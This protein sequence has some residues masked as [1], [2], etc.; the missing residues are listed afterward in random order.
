METPVCVLGQS[1]SSKQARWLFNFDLRIPDS[2]FV[3]I[4]LAIRAVCERKFAR[5]AFAKKEARD[6][7]RV[8]GLGQR[9]TREFQTRGCRHFPDVAANGLPA[10]HPLALKRRL[11]SRAAHLPGHET[12]LKF[13]GVS[14]LDQ[15]THGVT[16]R[17]S[18]STPASPWRLATVE[19]SDWPR[20]FR[21]RRC[22]ISAAAVLA[23]G[24]SDLFTTTMSA[25]SSIAIFCNCNR[26]P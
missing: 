24:K 19:T 11:G 17:K 4:H 5:Q 7:T 10:L 16:S 26:L 13:D 22:A 6:F 23:P 14:H 9:K 15:N 8:I 12:V 3:E 20:W 1:K 2:G 21:A 25:T 18:R